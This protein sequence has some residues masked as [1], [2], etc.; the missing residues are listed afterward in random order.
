MSRTEKERKHACVGV[1]IEYGF[2]CVQVRFGLVVSTVWIGSEYGFVILLDESASESH[3]Q[4]STRTPPPPLFSPPFFPP[5]PP[6]PFPP[7]WGL[8][9]AGPIFSMAGSLGKGSQKFYQRKISGL[10]TYPYVSRFV[11]QG[12]KSKSIKIGQK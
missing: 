8:G 9:S 3:T 2:G 11:L 12:R 4:N 1:P 10:Q 6:L 5:L 7:H